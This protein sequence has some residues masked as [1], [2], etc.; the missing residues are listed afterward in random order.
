MSSHLKNYIGSQLRIHR[1]AAGLNQAELGAQIERTPE[2]IS[3]IETGKSL[4]SINTLLLLAAALGTDVADF[5]PEGDVRDRVS[6]NRLKQEAE[7][8]QLVRNLSDQR[9]VI[10]LAQVKALAELG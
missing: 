4:P 6:A 1:R 8:M 3:N 5:L 7:M 10:A 2:A 9:L